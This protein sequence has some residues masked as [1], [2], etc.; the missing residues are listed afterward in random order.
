[1]IEARGLVKRFG[2]V[3]ALEDVG[4]TIDRG[5][6]VGFLGP[7][8]A[9]KT[10]TLR[11]LS[12]FLPADGGSAVVAG[13]DVAKDPM[14]VRKRLGYLP[15]GCPLYRDVSV[16]EHLQLG[17][18][19]R[20]VSG[21]SINGTCRDAAEAC[22]LLDVAGRPV[23]EL[24]K[25]YRQRVGLALAMLHDPD[26]LLL[27]E[28][29]SGLDPN[30]VAETRT[31]IRSIGK[32]R[33]V[34]LSTHVL[35]E[36]E[37]MCDRVLIIDQ[38]KIAAAG[39]KEELSKKDGKLVIVLTLSNPVEGARQDLSELPDVEH[40]DEAEPGVLEIAAKKGGDPGK[41]VLELAMGKSWP[42]DQVTRREPGLEELFARVTRRSK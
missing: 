30:Q 19:L 21:P 36:A 13:F 6:V 38:G 37:A 20:G 25:G 12:C 1:M 18:R 14:E 23:G 39:T 27:D 35:R 26:V 34:L 2:E 29:T 5:E 15:E 4:F 40:V 3:R 17:A 31:L 24:S 22:G 42:V 16:L 33:T 28:P 32:K 7:N 9:G 41:A 11:I 8:G 10:T